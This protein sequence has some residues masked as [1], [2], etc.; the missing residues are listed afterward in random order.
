MLL[1]QNTEWSKFLLGRKDPKSYLGS[2]AGKYKLQECALCTPAAS[3]KMFPQSN[4]PSHA[5]S[6]TDFRGKG[7]K[8]RSNGS[9]R[10]TLG[11]HHQAALQKLVWHQGSSTSVRSRAERRM[12]SKPRLKFLNFFFFTVVHKCQGLESSAISLITSP[13]WVEM[14]YPGLVRLALSQLATCRACNTP[15]V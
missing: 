2:V 5:D 10:I 1:K 14:F 8:R 4:I 11:F 13:L 9:C 6:E 15:P 7:E 3:P 12:P